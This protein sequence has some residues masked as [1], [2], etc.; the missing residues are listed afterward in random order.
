[1]FNRHES[2]SDVKSLSWTILNN[3]VIRI[4]H[5]IHFISDEIATDWYGH[6]NDL[7]YG[8]MMPRCDQIPALFS[9]DRAE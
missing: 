6:N 9:G 3:N 8:H 1:M 7:Q 5:N 2:L 4:Y